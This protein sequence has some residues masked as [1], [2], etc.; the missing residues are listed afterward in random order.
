MW[1]NSL[2]YLAPW[3]HCFT[4]WQLQFYSSQT[5]HFT[6]GTFLSKSNTE[7][8]FVILSGFL[9]PLGSWSLS[10]CFQKPIRCPHWYWFVT[11]FCYMFF[12][13][14][15][16]IS[17]SDACASSLPSSYIFQ[18]Y[19]FSKN[20]NFLFVNFNIYFL[21]IMLT[22]CITSHISRPQDDNIHKCKNA[23][24]KNN[25]LCCKSLLFV[26]ISRCFI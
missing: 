25:I 5:K 14:F 22:K 26:H 19:I 15:Q 18:I 7:L 3:V 24:K 9:S 8:L 11:T 1:Q 12:D 16:V 23:R 6:K 17:R 4:V 2:N 13:D 10:L 20:G 21:F